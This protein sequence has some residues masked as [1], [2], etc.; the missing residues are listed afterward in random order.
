MRRTPK[1]TCSPL[2]LLATKDHKQWAGEVT[3]FSGSSRAASV[4]SRALT[5]TFLSLAWGV[6]PQKWWRAGTD[7]HRYRHLGHGSPPM[8]GEELCL[9]ACPWH[10]PQ[11]DMPG[12]AAC[13]MS[14]AS[15]QPAFGFSLKKGSPLPSHPRRPH[16]MLQ[17]QV[18]GW[19]LTN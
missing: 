15:Q 5:E 9:H 18:C 4:W 8:I 1:Q 2:L 3:G 10:I 17:M 7:M 13:P 11:M 6:A 19:G 16:L 12:F 14:I